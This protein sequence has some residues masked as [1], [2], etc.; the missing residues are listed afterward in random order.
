MSGCAVVTPCL[1]A[2][3]PVSQLSVALAGVSPQ[4]AKASPGVS[5]E[6]ARAPAGV[7][8]QAAERSAWTQVGRRSAPRGDAGD[9]RESV[10]NAPHAA[11]RGKSPVVSGPRYFAASVHAAQ[12]RVDFDDNIESINVDCPPMGRIARSRTKLSVMGKAPLLIRTKDL[13]V[14]LRRSG[15]LSTWPT[16]PVCWTIPMTLVDGTARRRFMVKCAVLSSFGG[17]NAR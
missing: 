13:K 17:R 15:A 14:M 2:A 6:T 12:K 5:P 16:E 4:A 3:A 8:P 9:G 10:A 7:S 1:A 11:P